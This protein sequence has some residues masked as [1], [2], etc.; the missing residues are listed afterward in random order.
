M[1]QIKLNII[2]ATITPALMMNQRTFHLH[3]ILWNESSHFC[4]LES[5]DIPEIKKRISLKLGKL[6][7]RSISDYVMAFGHSNCVVWHWPLCFYFCSLLS[8]WST[9]PQFL[10]WRRGLGQTYEM[11][12]WF[13]SLWVSK[14]TLK[15]PAEIISWKRRRI[16]KPLMASVKIQILS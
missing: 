6:F 12:A 2:N 11:A 15:V 13:L 4:Y 3:F 16:S 10:S 8:S 7:Q 5:L 1:Y 14:W 9:H